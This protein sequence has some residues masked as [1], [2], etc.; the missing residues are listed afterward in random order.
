MRPVSLTFLLIALMVPAAALGQNA[1]SSQ[2]TGIA[3]DR[4][5]GGVTKRMTEQE[6]AGHIA[7]PPVRAQVD[8]AAKGVKDVCRRCRETH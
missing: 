1:S 4:F 2:T 6:S 5:M 3:P 7:A 8:K